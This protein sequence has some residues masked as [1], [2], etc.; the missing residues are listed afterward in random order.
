MRSRW[1]LRGSSE[2]FRDP[3]LRVEHR[4]YHYQLNDSTGTFTVVRMKDWAVILPIT[5]GGNLILVKQFRVATGEVNYE[6]PGGAIEHGE[7]HGKGA[8]RELMEETGCSGRMEL[9]SAVR[10][11]PAFMDNF[12]YTY[13]AR[14]CVRINGL[15]LDPFED[16]EPVEVSF[17]GFED[18]VR[19]GRI[20]H[21]ITLAAYGAFKALKG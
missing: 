11:N 13:L 9:L 2:V 7:D 1:E 18:M 17:S 5:Q 19:D 15:K 6:F 3:V 20:V 12:C 14:D 10:P 8:A 16:L 21:S 4:D